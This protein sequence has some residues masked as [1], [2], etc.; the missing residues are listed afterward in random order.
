MRHLRM[1]VD[2][3]VIGG[4]LDEEF[5]HESIALLD[6]ARQGR[7]TLVVS[8][9]LVDELLDA[10]PQVAA[11]VEGLPDECVERVFTT[12][13]TRHLRNRYLDA[14]VV[15]PASADD[16]LHVALATVAGA[17]MI[18]SWNFKHLVHYE[19]IRGYN[20]VNLRE[21]YPL[22]EIHSPKEVI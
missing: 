18:V 2:A 10:P 11:I 19:K 3:S 12:A 22:V 20:A 15:G 4:C 9:L 14:G 6:M 21:G 13:E 8:D 17:H 16:A 7:A 5:S 1:Y